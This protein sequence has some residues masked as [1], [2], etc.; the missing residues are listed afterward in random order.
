MKKHILAAFFV[1]LSS[2]TVLAQSNLITDD[3]GNTT[4]TIDGKKVKIHTDQYGNSKGTIGSAK[5]SS[6]TDPLGNTSGT[7]GKT[8]I[9]SNITSENNLPAGTI[10]KSKLVPRPMKDINPTPGAINN[11]IINS[12]IE[13]PGNTSGKGGYKNINKG[14]SSK[15]SEDF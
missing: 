5:I 7:V 6:H 1:I 9:N 11:S 3:S 4:G 15:L 8:V 10:G 13:N 14:T 2:S 12:Y